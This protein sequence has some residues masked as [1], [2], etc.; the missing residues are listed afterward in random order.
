[1][2]KFYEAHN[3]VHQL[4]AIFDALAFDAEYSDNLCSEGNV[5]LDKDEPQFEDRYD[6]ISTRYKHMID[7]MRDHLKDMD[8]YYELK[9]RI[10]TGSIKN[11]IQKSA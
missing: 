4:R 6:H 1:M 8:E 10:D 2:G 9:W 7:T 11:S 5:F 3:A